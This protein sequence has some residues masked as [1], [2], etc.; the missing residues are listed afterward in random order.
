[1]KIKDQI[2]LISFGHEIHIQ[3]FLGGYYSV[4][5]IRYLNSWDQIVLFDIWYSF[6]F[7]N[8]IIR[9]SVH[10]HYS[11]QLCHILLSCEPGADS[12]VPI[13]TSD[14]PVIINAPKGSLLCSTFLVFF[15]LKDSLH[16]DQ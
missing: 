3:Y 11:V 7:K 1:M 9:Y 14:V 16:F 10:I 15:T 6:I 4:L 12:S 8:R 13:S 2:F 5:S